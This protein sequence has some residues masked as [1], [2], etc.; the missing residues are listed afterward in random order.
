MSYTTLDMAILQAGKVIHGFDVLR[1]GDIP[2]MNAKYAK[3]IHKASGAIL[4]VS[5]RDDGQLLFSVGFRTLPEDDTGVFHI[6]EHSCLDGSQNYPLKEPFVNLLKTS[7]AVNLNA[8]T[9]Q[10]R[11]VYYYITTNQQDY[12]NMMSVYLDAVLYPLLL[13]DRRIFEKEAWHLEP[14]GEGGLVCSGVVYNEMQGHENNP[15]YILWQKATSQLFPERF[16]RFN[17]G[18]DP[19]AIRTLT[20]EQFKETYCRFYG[21][22]N[23]VCYLSGQIPMEALA[24]LDK[25]L[26]NRPSMGYEPPALPSVHPPVISPDGV[27]YYQLSDNEE[28]KDNTHVMLSY[29]LPSFC[30]DAEA[31]ALSLLSCYLA[32]TTQSPLSDAVLSAD[33]G[34]DFSMIVDTDNLEGMVCFSLGKSNPEQAEAF[35]DV[36]VATLTDMVAKGFDH[37]RLLALMDSYETDTRRVSL[38]TDAGFRI[39]E[40]FMRAQVLIGD[41]VPE[42]ALDVL[43]ARIAENPNYFEDLVQKCLLDSNHWAL[44]R[45]IPTRTVAEEK[46][47]ATQAFLDMKFSELTASEDGMTTLEAHMQALNEYLLAEDDPQAVAAVPHLMPKDITLP[48]MRRDMVEGQ[49]QMGGVDCTSLQYETDANGMTLAGLF[50][51]LKGLDE[52]ALFYVRC[53]KQTLLE[54][55]TTHHDVDTLCDLWTRLHADLAINFSQ[56][57]MGKEEEDFHHY[58]HIRVD[59]PEHKLYDTMM[60]LG[61]CL[62]AIVFDKE[63]LKRLLSG[64][65]M[66]RNRL[67]SS[68]N[69]TAVSMAEQSL[70]YAGAARWQLAG[71]PAYARMMKLSQ[72]FEAMADDLVLNLQKIYGYLFGAVKPLLY[73]VGS[74]NSYDIWRKALQALPV[75]I[76]SQQAMSQVLP[77]AKMHRAITI[78]G[79]VNYCAEVYDMSLAQCEYMPQMQVVSSYLYSTY[80]WDEIR[81]KGGA[82]GGS[83]VI[84]P[85]GLVAFV[86]YRD[87]RV[88]DTYSVYGRLP[89]WLCTHMPD[90][91]EVD[92]L[93]VSTLGQNYFIPQSPLDEGTA[94]LNRYLRGKTAQDRQNDIIKILTTTPQDFQNFADMMAELQAGGHGIKAVLGAEDA[95]VASGLFDDIQEL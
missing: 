87:P 92:S 30:K 10:D 37:D 20:Y 26:S 71:V 41:V 54:L 21:C 16:D 40:S 93:I 46:A 19:A 94:A 12:M 39:M 8:M 27:A 59:V 74:Q 86:S 43:K 51:D 78:P 90:K 23:A 24:Y 50:F 34:Q 33:V 25:V 3:L 52:D 2:H 15:G 17:S 48:P 72:D 61:E 75:K 5:D 77:T 62:T 79:G 85:Y 82:Y 42:Y 11:T 84:Y 9:Y 38:R 64:T 45:C 53:L 44:T 49:T 63:I 57:V 29:V 47:Q 58:L 1:V 67:I 95:I 65:G 36:V 60:L 6:L 56:T 88:A 4:Y 31:L 73:H 68:G 22:D 66:F 69:S 83:C 80:F 32:T 70:T 89:E 28:M 13:T 81:A 35:K 7:M 76:A 55:P 14:D 18:G 91:E